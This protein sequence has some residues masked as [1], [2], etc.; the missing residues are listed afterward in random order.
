VTAWKE[1]EL[2]I[3]RALGGE[4]RGPTGRQK[5]DCTDEVPFAVQVKRSSRPGP[6]V[7]SKWILQAR[8]D[9]RKEK[10]PWMVVTAGHN[11]RRPIMTMDFW[12]YVNE[13]DELLRLRG[14]LEPPK[15]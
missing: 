11:D 14:I 13:R 15:E 7:L 4:R 9:G 10:K 12:T 1:L 3:C 6:P 8:N 2:R 5:S